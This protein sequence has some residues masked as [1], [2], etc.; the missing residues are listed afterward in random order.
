[1]SSNTSDT[2]T[3][4]TAT[5]VAW[6][7]P[8]ALTI[9]VVG[10]LATAFILVVRPGKLQYFVM[11]TAFAYVILDIAGTANVTSSDASTA[12]LMRTL[13]RA[14]DMVLTTCLTSLGALSL[15]ILRDAKHLPAFPNWSSEVFLGTQICLCLCTTIGLLTFPR[16]ELQLTLIHTWFSAVM[17]VLVLFMAAIGL[18]KAADPKSD[19]ARCKGGSASSAKG[20]SHATLSPK[21]TD[22]ELGLAMGAELQLPATCLIHEDE[23]DLPTTIRWPHLHITTLQPSKDDLATGPLKRTGTWFA[24]QVEA[25]RKQLF[26]ILARKAVRDRAL[27]VGSSF[28]ATEVVFWACW[29]AQAASTDAA[30]Y[31]IAVDVT[32]PFLRAAQFVYCIVVVSG[33]WWVVR[34][35]WGNVNI[36]ATSRQSP[37]ARP[38]WSM[39]FQRQSGQ[40]YAV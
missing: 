14:T 13:M 8:V 40:V 25:L 34:T 38:P 23:F 33:M 16:A 29:I 26:K 20:A 1:M 24:S 30:K 18:L 10:F 4:A 28:V 32:Q 22:R 5:H 35:E 7:Y 31:T 12:N 6:P 19:E 3:L 21:S 39:A 2:I 11:L 9:S 27:I 36:R 15:H 37:G 17:G